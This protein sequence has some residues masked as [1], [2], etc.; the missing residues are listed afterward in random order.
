MTCYEFYVRPALNFNCSFKFRLLPRRLM[1]F[2]N[3]FLK[4]FPMSCLTVLSRL[5]F[6]FI[7]VTLDS[8]QKTASGSSVK[9]ILGKTFAGSPVTLALWKTESVLKN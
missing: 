7:I 3:T 1:I 8:A 9:T 2:L 4:L 5:S 6:Q